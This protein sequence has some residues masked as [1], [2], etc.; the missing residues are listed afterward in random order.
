VSM[1]A[2]SFLI[3]LAIDVQLQDQEYTH[4]S[5]AITYQEWRGLRQRLAIC[6]SF[7]SP[8]DQPERTG[9][10]SQLSCICGRDERC[11]GSE[12]FRGGHADN[13]QDRELD[14]QDQRR[15]QGG[16]CD[17]D[18]GDKLV[19]LLPVFSM[20]SRI[21]DAASLEIIINPSLPASIAR[22]EFC[23]ARA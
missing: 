9:Q 8:R 15:E 1:L 21:A 12:V 22:R 13:Q 17:G 10:I 4:A 5:D 18:G 7:Q 14:Q 3:V 23:P 16:D 19:H 20:A 2:R 11:A 6:L